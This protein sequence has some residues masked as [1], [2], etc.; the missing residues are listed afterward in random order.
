MGYQSGQ[1]TIFITGG[2]SGLG[3]E[4]GRYFADKGWFVGI[5]DVNE[6]GMAETAT[7]L[8]EGQS[9]THRLDV[10][11]RAQWTKAVSEFAAITGGT[12]TVLFNNAGIGEGGAIQD[13]EDAAIDRMIAINLTG[14]ISGTRAC[15]DM[16]K[17]TPDSC[18]LYTASAAGIYG[19]ADLSVYSATKFAVRGLAESHDI[20][21]RKH[22]IKSRSLMPGFIDTN[23]I[24]NVVEGTNQSGKE[25]LEEAGVMVSP[26]A[27]IGPA[28]WA[29]VHGDKV[30]TP[31]N[32]MAKQLAFAARWM[33]GRVRKQSVSLT[34]DLGEVLAG[35]E[36]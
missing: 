12:M 26:V 21:F 36:K 35:E 27:I 30:H 29:A 23:I 14:V 16:L 2:A 1:K 18:V 3:R 31:V 15:F 8:P 25:R 22:D 13:M 10:T 6:K 24:S 32:K 4:V 33:P 5:A 7:L 11:D 34:S 20:E 9:S 17:N 19:V 28:A